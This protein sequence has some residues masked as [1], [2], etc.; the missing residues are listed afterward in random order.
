VLSP[1]RTELFAEYPELQPEDVRQAL[2]LAAQN[3]DDLVV[4]LKPT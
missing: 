1:D 3:R 2:E 4:P